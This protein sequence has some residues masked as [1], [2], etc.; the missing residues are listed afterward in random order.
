MLDRDDTGLMP[1]TE[2]LAVYTSHYC[3]QADFHMGSD[4]LLADFISGSKIMFIGATNATF[5]PLFRTQVAIIQQA[6][7]VFIHRDTVRMH[8]RM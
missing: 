6:P 3:I 8:H 1:R 5:F 4:A 7:L 2:N